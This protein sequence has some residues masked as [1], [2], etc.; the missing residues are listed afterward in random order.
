[1]TVL[2]AFGFLKRGAT[3]PLFTLACDIV[4][5]H[6]DPAVLRRARGCNRGGS[7]G[8]RLHVSRFRSLSLSLS[9]MHTKRK[10]HNAVRVHDH[11]RI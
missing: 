5:L 9:P 8:R 11:E 7:G 4:D 3:A 6:N 1:M 10:L 2:D